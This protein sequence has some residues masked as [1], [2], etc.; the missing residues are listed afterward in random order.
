M[1]VTWGVALWMVSLTQ[2][3]RSV[4]LLLVGFDRCSS[5]TCRGL[6]DGVVRVAARGCSLFAECGGQLSAHVLVLL[7][8]LVVPFEGGL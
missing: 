3:P 5:V 2:P 1:V 4:D 7:S 6:G 8:Q